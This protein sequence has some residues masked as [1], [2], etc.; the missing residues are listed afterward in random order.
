MTAAMRN[1][2][3]VWTVLVAACGR[4]EPAPKAVAPLPA[5]HEITVAATNDR[6]IEE[7]YE[8]ASPSTFRFAEPVEGRVAVWHWEPH[9]EGKSHSFG[10]HHG[11]CVDYW[12][13]PD[14]E[15]YPEQPESYRMAFF[16]EGH[17]RGI[18]VEG[19]RNAPLE[20]DKWDEIWVDPTWPPRAAPSTPPK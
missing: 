17:L 11:W 7:R 16:G 15:G 13:T 8:L 14:Y 3:L 10:Y 19:S 1:S 4:A 9:V 5:D 12:F 18:F 6:V 2:T 20:L